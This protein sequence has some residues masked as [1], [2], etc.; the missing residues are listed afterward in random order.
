MILGLCRD[1][2]PPGSMFHARIRGDEEEL[3]L[4]L[5]ITIGWVI[6]ALLEIHSLVSGAHCTRFCVA[7]IFLH[8]IRCFR[9]L[10]ICV[11]CGDDRRSE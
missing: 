1:V 8:S 10:S 11:G 2:A 3:Q 9:A 5:F 7:S 4:E 6:L